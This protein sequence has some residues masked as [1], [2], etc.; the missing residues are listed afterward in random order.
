MPPRFDLYG[1]LHKAMRLA[2]GEGL[3]L[4]GR[5]DAG[6]GAGLDQALVRVEELLHLLRAELRQESDHI[7]AAIE[8]RHPGGA[9]QMAGA[10]CAHGQT[11][12]ELL[13]QVAILRRAAPAERPALLQGL[14]QQLALF[15]AENLKRMALQEAA[16][17]PLLWQFYSDAELSVLQSRQL[18]ALA[19][20]ERQAAL[21]WMTRALGPRELA[22]LLPGMREVM[23]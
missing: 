6:D 10:L 18:A 4:L 15:V 21:H 17:G 12:R 9:R 11:S 19:P 20:E 8:A 13:S 14:Y 7:H 3:A 23:G 1:P 16:H 5:V 22:E 2:M